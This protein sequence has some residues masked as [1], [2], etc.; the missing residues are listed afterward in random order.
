MKVERE[1]E[2]KERGC[3]TDSSTVPLSPAVA[4]AGRVGGDRTSSRMVLREWNGVM[5]AAGCN[6]SCPTFY[7]KQVCGRRHKSWD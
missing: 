4:C 7:E 5:E 2:K 1:G 3:D 6:C